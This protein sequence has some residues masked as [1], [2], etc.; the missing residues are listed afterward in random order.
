MYDNLL[1][2]LNNNC[3]ENVENSQKISEE[4]RQAESLYKNKSIE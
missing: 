2:E 4:L 3:K 1:E